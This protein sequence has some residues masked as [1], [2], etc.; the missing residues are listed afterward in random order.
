MMNCYIEII[1]NSLKVSETEA[2]SIMDYINDW[3]DIS[4]S[5]SSHASIVRYARLAQKG[6][7]A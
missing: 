5:N 2:K 7:G 3:Y 4:W 6:L 1:V